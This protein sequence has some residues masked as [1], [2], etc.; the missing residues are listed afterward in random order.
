MLDSE[1]AT[2]SSYLLQ[3]AFTLHRPFASSLHSQLLGG[4]NKVKESE[5]NFLIWG[6]ILGYVC[7]LMLVGLTDGWA[8]GLGWEAVQLLNCTELH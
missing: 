7:S 5:L 8:V 3:Q 2:E 4:V 6:L 1:V